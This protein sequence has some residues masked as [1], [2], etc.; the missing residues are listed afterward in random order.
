M[1][2]GAGDALTGNWP[3]WLGRLGGPALCYRLMRVA[4]RRIAW[5]NA[6]LRNR[7]LHGEG[8]L[9]DV[10]AFCGVRE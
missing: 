4:Q 5:R 6:S 7:L 10:L 3:S 2:L 9:D 1:I 8:S